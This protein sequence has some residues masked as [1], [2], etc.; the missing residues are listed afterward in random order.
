MAYMAMPKHKN[1]CPRGH[2]M[3]NFG[4]PLFGNYHPLYTQFV[5]T[6][7]MSGEEKSFTSIF[8]F[9]PKN[10]LSLEW[11]SSQ[12]ITMPYL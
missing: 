10:F 5:W 3:Y 11:G 1:P 12:K 7:P 8:Q 9:L 4:K 2:K 6:M